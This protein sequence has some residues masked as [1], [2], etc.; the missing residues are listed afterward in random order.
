MDASWIECGFDLSGQQIQVA[1]RRLGSDE[2]LRLTAEIAWYAD[3]LTAVSRA[4]SQSLD[5]RVVSMASPAV[6][7]KELPLVRDFLSGSAT[8]TERPRSVPA[9]HSPAGSY[10]N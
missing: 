7:A 4:A 10:T 3:A 9:R 5:C 1:V 6:V 8:H 2:R